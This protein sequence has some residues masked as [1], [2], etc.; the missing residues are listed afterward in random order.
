MMRHINILFLSFLFISS[1]N[2]ARAGYMVAD[3]SAK[4]FTKG[5][6][7][8]GTDI[9]V[10]GI[11]ESNKNIVAIITGPHQN[12]KLLNK[13]KKYWLWSKGDPKIFKNIPSYF[14]IASSYDIQKNITFLSSKL[15]ISNEFPYVPNIKKHKNRCEESFIFLKQRYKLFPEELANIE[16]IGSQIFRFKAYLPNNA[17]IGEYKVNIY[18]ISGDEIVDSVQLS[19][20]I[21]NIG[22]DKLITL[23]SKY[24]PLEYSG[25]AIAIA[26]LIGFLVSFLFR[27]D[28]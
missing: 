25:M 13:K 18:S 16:R 7:F 10:S 11:A 8:S 15:D 23:F 19:F 17:T 12:Y 1:G 4:T 24:H 14:F 26:L 20:E 5:V 28:K 2:L 6:N 3:L 9:T 22:T 21:N 27:K